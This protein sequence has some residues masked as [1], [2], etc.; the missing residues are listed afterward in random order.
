MF[1]ADASRPAGDIR[2]TLSTRSGWPTDIADA[3]N[4]PSDMATKLA[5]AHAEVVHHPQDVFDVDRDLV[6]VVR[7]VGE[8][9]ADH[10]DGHA[11]EVFGEC[12]EVRGEG[13]PVPAGSVQQDDMRFVRTPGLGVARTDGGS[14]DRHVD[15]PL[16]E[17]ELLEIQ[18]DAAVVR[19][20]DQ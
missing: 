12:S 20:I 4:A 10:V 16:A 15:E 3:T 17:L 11:V 8:P 5:D 1:D 13:L 14:V 6:V 9:V 18:P 7:L 2:I 19:G